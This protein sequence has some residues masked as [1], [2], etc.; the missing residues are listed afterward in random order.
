[1]SRYQCKPYREKDPLNV[2]LYSWNSVR[3]ETNDVDKEFT[4]KAG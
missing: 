2:E 1:M 3:R 4:A